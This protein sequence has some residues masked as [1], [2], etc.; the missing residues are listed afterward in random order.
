M[1][2]ATL[3]PSK[4]NKISPIK[5]TLKTYLRDGMI[6]QYPCR[7]FRDANEIAWENNPEI[8]VFPLGDPAY[9]LL[10]YLMKEHVGRGST[11]QE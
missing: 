4:Q 1:H 7:L 8:D 6:P 2:I 5:S 10:P 3:S 11:P 9:P